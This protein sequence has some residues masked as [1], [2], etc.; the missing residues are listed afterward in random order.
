M[1]NG[2]CRTF[3]IASTIASANLN[4]KILGFNFKVSQDHDI[5]LTFFQ[6]YQKIYDLLEPSPILR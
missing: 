3:S 4:R 6:C 2:L 5:Y 1:T